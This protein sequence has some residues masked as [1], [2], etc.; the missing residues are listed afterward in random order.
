MFRLLI[1]LTSLISLTQADFET[2]FESRTLG[3]EFVPKSD[4]TKPF[5]AKLHKKSSPDRSFCSASLISDRFVLTANHCINNMS[6]QRI[7]EN[8]VIL[9]NGS[10]KGSTVKNVYLPKDS[11]FDFAMLELDKPL[12]SS[13]YLKVPDETTIDKY[14]GKQDVAWLFGYGV[15]DAGESLSSGELTQLN[16]SIMDREG[17]DNI[18]ADESKRLQLDLAIETKGFICTDAQKDGER[19]GKSVGMCAG[20]SGGPLVVKE[21]DGFTQ[22]GVVSGYIVTDENK[23]NCG[24]NP[25]RYVNISYYSKWIKEVMSHQVQPSTDYSFRDER[26][27]ERRDLGQGNIYAHINDD[28][29]KDKWT[30]VGFGVYAQTL[31][32]LFLPKKYQIVRYREIEGKVQFVKYNHTMEQDIPL[33]PYEGFFMKIGG[34]SNNFPI[35]DKSKKPTISANGNN[36]AGCLPKRIKNNFSSYI[37][38][39]C[40]KQWLLLSTTAKIISVDMM[41]KDGFIIAFY[42]EPFNR[43]D[44]ID[45]AQLKEDKEIKIDL[46]KGFW[47]YLK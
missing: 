37:A 4:K 31:K 20:D 5:V 3:G 13:R 32:H 17:C 41:P 45:S 2:I 11:R 44:Y 12:P 33:L 34:Q 14:Y 8:I 43:Y 7:K 30:M 24:Q 19:R 27:D 29:K 47:L 42:N 22:I 10:D 26:I 23:L 39:A 21:D 46:F 9:Y 25:G 16:L 18:L 1:L 6:P 38:Q 36:Q 35:I 15:N 28:I 40:K